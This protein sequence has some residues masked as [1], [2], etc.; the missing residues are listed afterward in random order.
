MGKITDIAPQ[1][2]NKTRVSLFVDGAF[3]C[4]LE[5]ITALEHRLKIGDEVDEQKLKAAVFDSEVTAAF[6]KAMRYLGPRARTEKELRTYLLGKGFGADVTEQTMQ[7]LQGYG[8]I[9][10]KAFAESYIEGH[11]SRYGEKRLAIELRQKGVSAQIIQEALEELDQSEDATAAARK[12]LRTH[13]PNRFKLRGYLYGKGFS[14]S[15]IEA[16]TD[17]LS[18]EGVFSEDDFESFE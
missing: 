13:A 17:T 9:D 8:Y 6:E 14:A 4:G 12:Y 1:K 2:R 11:R 5:R 3:V 15:A 18:E 7:K 16:A 10:D